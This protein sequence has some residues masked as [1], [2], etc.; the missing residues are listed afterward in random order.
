MKVYNSGHTETMLGQDNTDTE[1]S[2]ESK[3]LK[4]T[5]ILDFDD[6]VKG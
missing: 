4:R 3:R 1:D 6:M 5:R 2:P